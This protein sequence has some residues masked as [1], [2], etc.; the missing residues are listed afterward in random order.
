MTNGSQV[1][2]FDSREVDGIYRVERE[3][4]CD[5]RGGDHGVVA[6][7]LDLPPGGPERGSHSAKCTGRLCIE[8]DG[9]EVRLGLLQRSLTSGPLLA[10]GCHQGA[11]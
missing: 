3:F 2:P 5:S 1:E 10:I 11:H 4:V 7:G 8:G 6:S 9:S